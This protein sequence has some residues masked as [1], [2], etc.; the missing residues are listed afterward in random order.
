M[1][2]QIFAILLVLLLVVAFAACGTTESNETQATNPPVADATDNA[3]TENP[4]AAD[5]GPGQQVYQALVDSGVKAS[6]SKSVSTNSVRCIFVDD[7]DGK[8]IQITC[9]GSAAHDA[10]YRFQDKALNNEIADLDSAENTTEGEKAQEQ[11]LTQWLEARE[12][13]KEQLMDALDYY[14]NLNAALPAGSIG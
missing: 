2:K 12:L 5:A 6:F 4:D 9:S 11:A 10:Q 3:E 8:N 1:R 13:T 14:Y 7:A